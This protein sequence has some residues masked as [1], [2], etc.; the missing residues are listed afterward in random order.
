MKRLVLVALVAAAC[1]GC[2]TV[3]KYKSVSV[4]TDGAGKIIRRVES[5][6]AAQTDMTSQEMQLKLIQL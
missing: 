4:E 5:E 6:S 1:A 3:R 2:N